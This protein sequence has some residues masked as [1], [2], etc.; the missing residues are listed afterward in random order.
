M[1]NGDALGKMK[2]I[3]PVI[4][5]MALHPLM[6]MLINSHV[7]LTAYHAGEPVYIQK[8]TKVVVLSEVC[9]LAEK[10]VLAK[11]KLAK[12]TATQRSLQKLCQ[13]ETT[14]KE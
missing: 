11:G 14:K 6:H 4:D 8:V 1:S 10:K 7:A 13:K 3:V 2:I 5:E 12:P 9:L